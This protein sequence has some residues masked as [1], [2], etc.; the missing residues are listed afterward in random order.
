M[1]SHDRTRVAF[2]NIVLVEASLCTRTIIPIS[3][4]DIAFFCANPEGRRF[5][6]GKVESSYGH[7]ACLIMSSV[8]KLK[9]FLYIYLKKDDWRVTRNVLEVVQAYL[10][11]N[12]RRYHLYCS[13]W[14]CAHSV[15]QPSASHK[16]G[17]YDQQ[18]I[19]AF[20]EQGDASIVYPK[21]IFDLNTSH[22]K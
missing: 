7:F 17:V 15:S 6:V 12:C 1:E 22:Q 21:A 8:N 10:Q 4:V 3:L 2:I 13:L 19:V 5:V 14:D 16:L 11:A 18:Q 20:L 9:G